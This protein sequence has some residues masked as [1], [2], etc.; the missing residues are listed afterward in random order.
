ME[1]TNFHH[2]TKHQT[3]RIYHNKKRVANWRPFLY[4]KLKLQIISE[5]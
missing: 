5:L 1:N 3:N 4:F 2:N